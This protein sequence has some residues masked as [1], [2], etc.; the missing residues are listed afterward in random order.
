[1]NI[2]ETAQAWTPY[3]KDMRFI[4]GKL[5]GIEKWTFTWSVSYGF[6]GYLREGRYCFDSLQNALGFYNEWD[7]IEVPVVGIDGCTAVK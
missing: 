1:M 7:G 6:D 3:V 5:C 4:N 2:G